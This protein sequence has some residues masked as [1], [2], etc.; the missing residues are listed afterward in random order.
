MKQMLTNQ[1]LFHFC[2][3]FSILLQSGISC[4]EGL[5][6]FCDDSRSDRSRQIFMSLLKSQEETGSFSQALSD[7]EIFPASMI[8]YVQA[9]EETGCLDEVMK[10]LADHYEQELE[11]SA[12][13]RN[14]VTYPLIML[15]MMGAVIVILLVKVL[16]VFQQVFRQMGMQMN[17]LSAGLLRIGSG[18]SRYSVVFLVLLGILI[19]CILFTCCT[20]KGRQLS[21]KILSRIPRIRKIPAAIDYAR[22]TQAVSM[23]IRSGLDP[24]SGLEL[25]DKLISQPLVKNRLS[26]TIAL[27]ND[28][29]SFADAVTESDLFSGMDARLISIGVRTGTSDEVMKKLSD[30]CSQE[31]LALTEGIISAVEPTCVILLSIMV[32]LVLLSVMMPLLGLLSDMLV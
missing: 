31:A 29:A 5:Q 15:G 20:E 28:G 11:I 12:G 4:T 1:E 23:G 18:L 22:L 9:G 3:Q 30:R 17:G 25:A 8:S 7:A 26:K 32:G 16:P 2:E 14:A 19:L 21:R 10:S 6:I 27:L 24:Q 13:I